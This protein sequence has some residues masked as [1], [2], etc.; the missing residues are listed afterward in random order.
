MHNVV[1]ISAYSKV[2]QLYIYILFHNLFHHG[3]SQATKYISL[4]HTVG[5]CGLFIL[6]IYQFASANPKLANLPFPIFLLFGNQKSVLCI[7]ELFLFHRYVHLCRILG[8]TYTCQHMVF[9]FLFL[10]YFSQY[11]NLQV[12]KMV[13]LKLPMPS[14]NLG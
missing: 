10:T 6:H 5:P 7:C 1:L 13:F 11:D 12:Q 4:Y 14:R 2:S 8:S 9:V 3:L